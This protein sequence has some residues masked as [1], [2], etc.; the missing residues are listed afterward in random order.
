[1]S[2]RL[3]ILSLKSFILQYY[4]CYNLQDHLYFWVILVIIQTTTCLNLSLRLYCITLWPILVDGTELLSPKVAILA[5][6]AIYS[7]HCEGCGIIC[8]SLWTCNHR[9]EYGHCAIFQK[10]IFWQMKF[11]GASIHPALMFICVMAWET[12]WIRL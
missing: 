12:M 4:I 11:T 1:M 6:S 3:F 7:I 5:I 2:Y 8:W 10:S 9:L